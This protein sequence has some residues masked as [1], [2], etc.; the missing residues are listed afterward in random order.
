MKAFAL[1]S[2]LLRQFVRVKGHLQGF[3]TSTPQCVSEHGHMLLSVIPDTDP[4]VSLGFNLGYNHI[5]AFLSCGLYQ[6][7]HFLKKRQK[8]E[9]HV[10]EKHL[11]RKRVN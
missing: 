11:P 4:D 10:E 1:V 8:L 5:P 6:L 9:S 7:G 3:T 2:F